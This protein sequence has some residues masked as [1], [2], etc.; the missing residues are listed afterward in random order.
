MNRTKATAGTTTNTKDRKRR[1]AGTGSLIPPRPGISKYWAVQ[2][3]DVNGDQIRRTRFASG[4]K[5]IGKLKPGCDPSLPESWSGLTEAKELAREWAERVGK[6]DVSV[7]HDP[8]QMTYSTLRDLYLQDYTAQENESLRKNAETGVVYV[9]SLPHLDKFMGYEQDGDSGLK[10][11]SITVNLIDK[12]KEQRKAEGAANGTINRSLAA[13]R[14]MFG[15]A[16]ERGALKFAPF[17]KMLPEPKQPRQG[18]LGVEDHQKLYDALPEYVR[19]L[20]QTGYHTGMRLG[21]IMNLQWSNVDLANES[22]TLRPDQTKTEN[23]RTIPMIDGLPAMF[24]A[25]RR[26][27]PEADGNDFVFLSPKGKKIG[28]FIKAWRNACIKAGI[29]TKK[30]GVEITSHFDGERYEGFLFHDLRRSFISNM[31]DACVD[32][33]QAM[34]ISGHQTPE[35]YKRYSINRLEPLQEAGKKLAASLK[36]KKEKAAEEKPTTKLMIVSS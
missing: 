24:E 19:P 23:G 36:A 16:I 6:G 34:A 17:V 27:N 18:F 1:D 15:L 5:V 9:D 4:K 2:V 32:P 28:S 30:N 25:L 13:L 35:V 12:F 21:E 20:L 31:N 3:R 14:R 7:G 8:S 29:K 22:I 33:L 10:V 11:S 26:K